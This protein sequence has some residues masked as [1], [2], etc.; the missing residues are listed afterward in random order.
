MIIVS[1]LVKQSISSW[2]PGLLVSKFHAFFNSSV[3]E[4]W[5]VDLVLYFET[6][7]LKLWYLYDPMLM[8]TNKT[9]GPRTLALW[10]CLTAAVGMTLK[11]EKIQKWFE[12][13]VVFW[14]F[15]SHKVRPMFKL[16]RKKLW[17]IINSKFKKSK[18]YFCED[19]SE[20]NSGKVLNDSIVIWWR[21]SILN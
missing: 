13:G 11:Y 9:R 14:R 10:D 4:F 20:E 6:C 1:H 21:S 15:D 17:K 3:H 7:R 8:K 2:V 19:Y 5:G 16:N 12:G 18:Q